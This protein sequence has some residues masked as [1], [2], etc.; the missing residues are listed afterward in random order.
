MSMD[1]ATPETGANGSPIWG[2]EIFLDLYKGKIGAALEI[3]CTI[4][5]RTQN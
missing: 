1:L 3:G 5:S 4:F 2:P